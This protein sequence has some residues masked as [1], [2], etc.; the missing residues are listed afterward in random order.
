M[1]ESMHY[2]TIVAIASTVREARRRMVRAVQSR[3][4]LVRA[5][6]YA[7]KDKESIA[8]SEIWGPSTGPSSE[9]FSF[10][11]VNLQ[12]CVQ[13]AWLTPWNL[14]RVFVHTGLDG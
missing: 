14:E 13:T 11:Y 2:G 12:H 10:L 3:D 6:P 4:F 7:T 9:A 8:K 1:V 5:F